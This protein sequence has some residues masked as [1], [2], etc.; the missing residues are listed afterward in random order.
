VKELYKG[1][2]NA[3]TIRK[4]GREK[5]KSIKDL[6][7]STGGKANWRE[8]REGDR[9][10]QYEKEAKKLAPTHLRQKVTGSEQEPFKSVGLTSPQES[11]RGDI[12]Q[13]K[14]I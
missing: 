11:G 1:P 6:W 4:K 8:Q 14:M 9:I 5:E 10:G 2:A 3:P 12:H 7:D 13:C